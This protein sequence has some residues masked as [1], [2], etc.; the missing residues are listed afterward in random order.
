MNPLEIIEYI[1]KKGDNIEKQKEYMTA[2]KENSGANAEYT[3]IY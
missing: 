1:N 2:T 3:S